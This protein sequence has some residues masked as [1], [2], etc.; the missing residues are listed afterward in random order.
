MRSTVGYL[1]L[2]HIGMYA[3][4]WRRVAGAIAVAVPLLV[5]FGTPALA[6]NPGRNGRIL[7]ASA[8]RVYS[9]RPSGNGLRQLTHVSSGHY[10]WRPR[11][12]SDGRRIVYMSDQ[13]G[14]PEIWV[15]QMNGTNHHQVSHDPGFG[16][17]SPTWSPK[18][19]IVFSRC[20][21][22]L[23][24]CHIATM[25]ADGTHIREITHG[26]AHD[27][28]GDGPIAVSPNGRRLAFVSDRGG[29]DG[30]IWIVR[31]NGSHLREIGPAVLGP[32]AP[33]DWSPD[34]SRILGN[35]GTQ[36]CCTAF[37]I[38]S[39][40]SGLHLL[41]LD[42]LANGYSPDG[43]LILTNFAPDFTL[44]TMRA[45]GTHAMGFP[46]VLPEADFDSF[47]WAPAR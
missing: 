26:A 46:A 19:A 34:G 23:G 43:R 16:F 44:S 14:S 3:T 24:T 22:L 45:D 10:A 41:A 11:A 29:Y 2:R 42:A 12:S 28:V 7:F 27:G 13:T 25:H 39:D 38:R 32:S 40:G 5:S 47:T 18:G 30:R 33:V 21:N 15:M 36:S 20:S 6:T 37:T 1:Q 17:A 9:V 4:N 31:A 35:A 8:G